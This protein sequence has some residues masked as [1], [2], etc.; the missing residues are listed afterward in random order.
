[1]DELQRLR[2]ENSRLKAR[3]A[4][5]GVAWDEDSAAGEESFPGADEHT[6]SRSTNSERIALFRSL[7]RGRTDVHALRWESNKGTSG[8]SPACGNEWKP[9]I[10]YKPKIK[11]SECEHSRFLPVT[12]Q[13]I[14]DHLA[15][16]QTV[17]VY[18]LL[19]DDT[20]CFLA[21]DFDEANWR[22][23]IRALMQS[24]RELEVPAAVEI[25]RSGNGV[26][27]WVFFAE[28]VPAREARQLG[29]AL[30]S[31]TCNRTRQLSLGSYDRFFPNQDMLPKGGFGNLIALPLQKNAREEARS[32]F[33]DDDLVP[34]SD[35]WA[36]L[37]SIR[38]LTRTE[39]EDAIL[40]AS[41]GRHPLDVSFVMDEDPV[42]VSSFRSPLTTPGFVPDKA[43]ASTP[44]YV[45]GL[46]RPLG[47]GTDDRK[48]WKRELPI[49]AKIPGPLPE[50]VTLVLASQIFI[51]KR[52]LPQALRNR[53][54][55]LAAFQN[56]EFYRAQAM[57]LPVW[58]KPRIIGCAENFPEHIALP[59]GCLEDV[60]DL[61][62][63]NDIRPSIQDERLSGR[64]LA[65]R[66]TGALR[67]DQKAALRALT[68]Y[69]VGVLCA[70][71]GFGKTVTAAAL[72]ARR[73]VSTLVLVHR[74]ELM[75]Q[76]EEQLR[77]FLGIPEGGLGTIGGGKKKP[78]GKI[79]IAVL[80][81]LS[82]HEDLPTLLDEYGQ[83]IVDECHHLPAFSFESILKQ[84]K[85]HYV[86]GLTATPVRRDG[87]HPIINMQC[88]PIR[89]TA[90]RPATA[91]ARLE[92]WP[93]ILPSPT[94]RRMYPSSRSSGC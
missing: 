92:V 19:P 10:C 38:R 73:K 65:V 41:E 43:A 39:L 90:A 72:I 64:Q 70:P 28:P 24:C 91:P 94:S 40:R 25:S 1:M 26:H 35:Q 27:A 81:S 63:G 56:P 47:R 5:L 53:L 37:D 49:S 29:A 14:Y 46:S 89:H 22:E 23:D 57:R 67:K 2:E 36:F 33:V 34:F 48:P 54:I 82:R 71:P 44:S 17:G 20:C 50:S 76:W 66:F 51:A 59:R 83:I 79:D 21:V 62:R 30:I 9:G 86:V 42:A 3:L 80:Q 12:D 87:H 8:Y 55:R 88:G 7:F 11:C 31:H 69:E 45:S 68:K 15:G 78:S 13:V 60:V 85:A 74:T 6:A 16:R 32:V 61:L 84:A 18:P 77:A 52:D 93:R 4:D 58:N 75:R